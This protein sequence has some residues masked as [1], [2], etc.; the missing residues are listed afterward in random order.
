MALGHL[1]NAAMVRERGQW[2]IDYAR[3]E[4][5][6][7]LSLRPFPLRVNRD[8]RRL[9]LSWVEGLPEGTNR[10]RLAFHEAAGGQTVCL[11]VNAPS[12]GAFVEVLL[13]K[14]AR[15]RALHMWWM[16]AVRGKTRWQSRYLL[17]PAGGKIVVGWLV[18]G[19][20]LALLASSR[21][22]GVA[23]VGARVSGAESGSARAPGGFGGG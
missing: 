13:P 12:R 23:A 16:P 18:G 3:V 1:L 7:G 5:A 4:L 17:L 15:S 10:I 2:G 11:E 19:R 22:G 9:R 6:E 14:W 21:E 8:G 20:R